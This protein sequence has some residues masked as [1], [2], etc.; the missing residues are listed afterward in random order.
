MIVLL[1]L[2]KFS[3]RSAKQIGSH[4]ET[5]IENKLRG[6]GSNRKVI[7]K[8]FNDLTNNV[9]AARQGNTTLKSPLN[10]FEMVQELRGEGIF[11]PF[12]EYLVKLE[13]VDKSVNELIAET[14]TYLQLGSSPYAEMVLSADYTTDDI[15]ILRNGT[16]FSCGCIKKYLDTIAESYVELTMFNLTNENPSPRLRSVQIN[17]VDYLRR[18]Y[19]TRHPIFGVEVY[20]TNTKVEGYKSIGDV[21]QREFV[22]KIL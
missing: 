12:E 7:Y 21:M 16:N 6:S 3:E 9:L 13:G 4:L 8:S 11:A 10:Y 15:L 5:L 18:I 17:T 14:K 19:N 20:F 1:N 2:G 22:D